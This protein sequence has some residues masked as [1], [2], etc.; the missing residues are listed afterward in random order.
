[1][2]NIITTYNVLSLSL[3]FS[4]SLFLQRA[5]ANK[6]T[7]GGEEPKRKNHRIK[8]AQGAIHPNYM[9]RQVRINLDEIVQ[10]TAENGTPEEPK[11]QVLLGGPEIDYQVHN[12][13]SQGG[14]ERCAS[15]ERGKFPSKVPITS[16]FNALHQLSRS[17]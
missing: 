2:S 14:K 6:I 16:V 1:M 5:L 10:E 9:S 13:G 11:G 3:S 15:K 12:I 8:P 17:H 4:D 7:M